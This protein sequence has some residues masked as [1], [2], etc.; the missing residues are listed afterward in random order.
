MRENLIRELHNG[1]LSGNSGME[2]TH[3]L[4]EERSYWYGI[5][6]NVKKWVEN[7]RIC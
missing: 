1:G 4:V 6:N 7:C 3:A 2:K 5:A